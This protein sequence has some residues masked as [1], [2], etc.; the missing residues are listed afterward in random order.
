MT[1]ENA[2]K[3]ARIAA[4]LDQETLAELSGVPQATVSRAE[5][6]ADLRLSTA[7][8]LAGALG[9]SVDVA[10]ADHAR[11]ASGASEADRPNPTQPTRRKQA[12]KRVPKAPGPAKARARAPKKAAA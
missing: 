10:F 1:T 5:R 9:L 6:G 4:G 3:R 7:F 11:R 12:R 2:F 8:S